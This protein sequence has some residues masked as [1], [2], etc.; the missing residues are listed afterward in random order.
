[1]PDNKSPIEI[2][3]D[4][5]SQQ[6]HDEAISNSYRVLGENG[7]WTMSL[8]IHPKTGMHR[9]CF[10]SMNAVDATVAKWFASEWLRCKYGNIKLEFRQNK[11]ERIASTEDRVY[12]HALFTKPSWGSKEVSE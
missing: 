8:A 2:M 1:M 9:Q 7:I 4:E 11:A 10:A 6:R 3:F 12:F 5:H